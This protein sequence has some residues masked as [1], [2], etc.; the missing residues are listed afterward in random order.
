MGQDVKR[1]YAAD[2]KV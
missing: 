2:K 1:C